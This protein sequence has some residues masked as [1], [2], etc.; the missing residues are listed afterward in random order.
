MTG[1]DTNMNP[2]IEYIDSL[3]YQLEKENGD[4]V[5]KTYTSNE[6]ELD[7]LYNGVGLRNISHAGV[8]ELK[9]NDVLDYLHRISTN[10]V[11]DLPK[12]GL[13]NTIFTTDKGRIID[14][15]TL[16]N[17]EGHQ[18]MIC[19]DVHKLKVI[20]W[21]N[22]YIIT[23]D[24]KA[25]DANG[26]YALLEII[27]PQAESLITLVC[28]NV[29]NNIQP[30]SFKIFNAEG[31][32]FFLLKVT[33][34]NG[35]IKFWVI[36]DS[37]NA[38]KF[39]RFLMEN[40]GLF[41]FNFVGEES[42]N[43]YRIE[44]G[45]LT[46]PNEINDNYNPLEAGLKEFINFKKGCY[47][48]QEVIARLDTYDK[49]QNQLCGFVLDEKPDLNSALN[50]FDEQG[51]EIGN[52]TSAVYSVRLR[53]TISLGYVKKNFSAEGTILTIKDSSGKN[54]NATVVSIPFKK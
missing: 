12:E 45:F 20:S 6:V 13:I 52:I 41:N 46:A 16:M 38:H 2:L 18:L 51:N 8:I 22:K 27:G 53:K 28:G 40:K 47:I 29:I 24:V 32:L 23:D 17:F 54:F 42:F 5:V 50:I 15:C 1:V 14:T 3:G 31:M 30:D 39:T 4:G 33:Q 11:K 36:A 44:Q 10:A 25:N 19:S 43:T 9:G 7:S 34:Q 37:N 26:K 35:G 49:V 48:G 21:I